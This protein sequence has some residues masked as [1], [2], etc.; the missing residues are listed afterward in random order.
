MPAASSSIAATS[1]GRIF[2]QL[3]HAALLCML[4]ALTATAFNN[5][6]AAAGGAAQTIDLV[7]LPLISGWYEGKVVRYITTD[8]SDA[9]AA[10]DMGANYVPRLAN[11][12]PDGP[13]MP[14]RKSAVERIYAFTNFRQGGVL[15]SMPEPTGKANANSN[16]SPLWQLHKVTWLGKSSPRLLKSEEEVLAAEEAGDVRIDKTVIIVN[17]PVVM[18]EAGGRLPGITPR[19]AGGAAEK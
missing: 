15:P 12:I 10:A 13:P 16:Y 5:A 19:L 1:S 3:R 18:S 2:K 9:Q 14:G 7:Q 4:W 6:Q 8:V 11:A 17:C